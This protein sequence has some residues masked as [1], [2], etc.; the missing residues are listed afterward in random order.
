M[1]LSRPTFFVWALSTILALL[2]VALKFFFIEVSVLTPTVSGHLF[3]ALLMSFV[4]LWAG[5]V[6][7]GIRADQQ[8]GDTSNSAFRYHVWKGRPEPAG[9][10][11][12]YDLKAGLG[13]FSQ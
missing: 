1:S 4:L 2:V 9:A 10:L 6:F 11:V 5:T 12:F 8:F 7:R 3:E 13:E